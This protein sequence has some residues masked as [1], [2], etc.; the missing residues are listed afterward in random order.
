MW[1][2]PNY[3]AG[4]RRAFRSVSVLM[5]LLILVS[6]LTFPASFHEIAHYL[7][8]H[9]L[10]EAVS[11]IVA[12]LIFAVLWASR[13]EVL[14]GNM[15]LLGSTFLGV[16][17]LDFLHVLAYQGMPEL[18]TPNLDADKAIYF[19]LLARLFSALGLLAIAVLAWKDRAIRVPLGGQVV[20]VLVLVAGLTA[21]YFLQPDSIPQTFIPGQG[22]T[23][24]K[25]FAEYGLIAL[26][27]A[28][29]LLFWLRMRQPRNYNV[30]DLFVAACV[31]AQGEFF[32]TLYEGVTDI[33]ILFGHIYKVVAYLFLY[34][35][36]FVE[37]VQHPYALLRDSQDRLQATLDAMPDLVF[38]MDA[39][40]RY[41]S[42]HTSRPSDLSEPADQL[43]GRTVSDLLQPRD[44]RIVLDALQEA[45]VQGQ[46]QG[47]IITLHDREG[48][49]RE[50]ELSVARK[51]VPP[52]Q[53]P[54]FVVISRDVTARRNSEQALRTLST[55]VVQ[56]PVSMIITDSQARVEFV[57]EA[58]TRISGYTAA[59][60]VG[61]SLRRLK[62]AR[63]PATKFRAMWEQLAQGLAWR[64]EW[65]NLSKS[66]REYTESVLIYP[67]RDAQGRVTNYLAHNEDVTEKRRADERIRLLSQFDQLTGLPNRDQLRELCR[68]AMDR[69][70]GMA[71]LWMDL[72]HFKAVNDSLGHHVGDALLQ[73]MARRLRAQLP[74]AAFLSRYSGDDF[75]ALVPGATQQQAMAQARAL[76]QAVS[77]PLRLADQDIFSSATIGVALYPDDAAAFDT[78]LKSAET[79]MYRAKSDGRHRVGM[80]TP[81]MQAQVS[82]ELMLGNA[83]KQAL[84]N[85][86]LF[87]VYQPQ[88][89]LK[90][91]AILGA[92]ALLRWESPQWGRV[93]PSEFIRIAEANGL[94]IPIGEWVLRTAMQQL[95]QWR[96]Q[97]LPELCIAVNLSAVQF[98]QPD[99]PGQI[100]RILA[101]TGVPA[102]QLELELTEAVAMKA[103]ESVAQRMEELSHFG[104]RF[105][106]DDFGTGYSSLSYLK[107][108]KLH[109]LKI[110]QS[111][112]R[113]INVDPEDQ[114]IATAII[115][116][117]RSLGLRTI[118]EGV[119]TA[120][121]QEFLRAN[122][123]EEVQGYYYS[124]PLTADVFAA[125]VKDHRT[126]PEA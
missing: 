66:G 89:A 101:D 57:N 54:Q 61:R 36:V 60:V 18:I 53:A 74:A 27:L 47:K 125:F 43:L 37:A 55:A 71:A 76:L 51:A 119:E 121:Q 23:S 104:V 9:N 26:Y 122:G 64:G 97:G 10:T 116:L 65:Q 35:A 77:L 52:G 107:R 67:V 70:D 126:Q 69:G 85:R 4:A 105:A 13:H 28:A 81:E 123:C 72:D 19:W 59:E 106:I 83:L 25:I 38:N 11:V 7:P 110:D 79:A 20:G 102:S 40:G 41:L 44:A 32:L 98:N 42:V 118:A 96:D 29:A 2:H 58:F 88:F 63:T 80:F 120:E 15:V 6:S 114:A 113:D 17:L 100:K 109:K 48:Q 93:P 21:L 8:L 92:E 117:S 45:A 14:P 39:D 78:L 3:Q 49:S 34:R 24:F 68:D 30:S 86:E 87:L 22:L 46:S 56:S 103:P 5:A 108:F 91:G 16:A 84:A 124:R 31:M 112:V 73:E 95:R 90:D 75:V 12:S 115:Q 50:F 82:R 1:I 62:P 111:F 94:I 33:Y 99:L